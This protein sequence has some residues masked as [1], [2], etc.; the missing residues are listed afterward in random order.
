MWM[1][2]KEK[3]KISQPGDDQEMEESHVEKPYTGKVLSI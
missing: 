3:K 2:K 1:A